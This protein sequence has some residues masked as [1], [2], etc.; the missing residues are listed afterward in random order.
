MNHSKY[1]WST[2]ALQ[3]DLLNGKCNL[4]FL[5][6]S[7]PTVRFSV[8]CSTG[9]E[10]DALFLM[11]VKQGPCTIASVP[12]R[13]PLRANSGLPTPDLE[14]HS[15]SLPSVMSRV[16]HWDPAVSSWFPPQTFQRTTKHLVSMK[17][18]HLISLNIWE[19]RKRMFIFLIFFLDNL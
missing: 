7:S 10:T 13:I 9:D 11:N 15:Q 1:H 8:P 17:F 16:G 14:P 5:A 3:P 2:C 6:F 18:K 19:F 12:L 4:S